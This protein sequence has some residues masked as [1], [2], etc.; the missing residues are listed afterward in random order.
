M[1][2]EGFISE[3]TNVISSIGEVWQMDRRTDWLG[4]YYNIDEFFRHFI[5]FH[6]FQFPWLDNHDSG[7]KS[8]VDI[9]LALIVFSIPKWRFLI[10]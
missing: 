9:F 6:D 3:L 5:K 7:N 8:M 2:I 1:K 10:V 4:S